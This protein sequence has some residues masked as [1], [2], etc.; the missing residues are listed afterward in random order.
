MQAMGALLIVIGVRSL[1]QSDWVMFM[2][3]SALGV[4]FLIGPK[5][6]KPLQG[7]RKTLLVVVFVLVIIRLVPLLTG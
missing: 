6:S 5:G 7:F 3:L 4:S 1:L 2:M